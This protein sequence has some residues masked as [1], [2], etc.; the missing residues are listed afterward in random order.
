M[1]QVIVGKEDQYY[2]KK[3]NEKKEQGVLYTN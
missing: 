3:Y 2:E 1:K